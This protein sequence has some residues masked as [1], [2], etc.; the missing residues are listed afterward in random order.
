MKKKLQIAWKGEK[1]F[2]VGECFIKFYFKY[3]GF[4]C[5]IFCLFYVSTANVSSQGKNFEF[6]ALILRLFVSS[7]ELNVLLYI[8]GELKGNLQRFNDYC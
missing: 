1:L 8:C 3:I 7:S 6:V 4:N 2:R 5:N